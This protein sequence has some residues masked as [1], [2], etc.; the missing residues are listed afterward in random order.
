MFG[1]FKRHTV[2][3]SP[4][5]RGRITEG[6]KP[7]SG[8]QVAR[9]LIYEGYQKGKEHLEHT[10]TNDNGEFSFQP[11][12]IKS[13]MP[14]D[15]F[16]QNFP[17]MQAIYI[18]RGDQLF[19]LWSVSKVTEPIKPLSDLLLQLNAD[20]KNKEVHHEIDTYGDE[21][22][23]RQVVISICHWQG[24]QFN[25]YYNNELISSYEAINAIVQSESS[26]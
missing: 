2:E 5:V 3:M 1:F 14:G 7:V 19:S 26:E 6:G 12:T 8:L 11:F 10:F 25:T 21:E 16:G 22:K 4:E 18:E 15:L 20:L 13:R 9:S 23:A 17:V 24:E